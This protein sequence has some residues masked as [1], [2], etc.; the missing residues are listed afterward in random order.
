ML[1]YPGGTFFD[2][3]TR[4]YSFFQ[5]SISDLGSAISW[6]GQPNAGLPFLLGAAAMLCLGSAAGFVAMSR[7]YS[8]SV[9]NS[10]LVRV[11]RALVLFAGAALMAASAAP[12]DQFPRLHGRLTLLALGSFPAGT[13]LLALA[14]HRQAGIR[15]RVA[16][17]WMALT[18]VVAAWGA[19]IVRQPV[20]PVEL[21]VAVGMQKAVC[22]SLIAALLFQGYEAERLLAGVR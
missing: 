2:P 9:V 1:R 21:G 18:I 11:A 8:G 13:A 20:T 15:P 3:G 22:L 7:A 12:Q 5:N 6:S 16:V 4:G 14:T 10:R 17:V 19:L